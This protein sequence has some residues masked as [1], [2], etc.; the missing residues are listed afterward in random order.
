V[1]GRW[2]TAGVTQDVL[3]HL[4][5]WRW[6]A[7]IFISQ[8]QTMDSLG[9]HILHRMCDQIGIPKMGAAVGKQTED[10]GALLDLPQELSAPVKNGAILA[11]AGR[12]Q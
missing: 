9:H 10:P 6:I 4:I 8:G 5:E 3:Y 11:G 2:S 1:K 7:Q 12:G